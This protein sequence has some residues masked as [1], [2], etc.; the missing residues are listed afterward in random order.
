M[1]TEALTVQF[2]EPAGWSVVRVCPAIAR[3]GA[4]V[5]AIAFV[6]LVRIPLVR[7]LTG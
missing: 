5:P 3:R 2:A 4:L 7:I 6:S 1:G